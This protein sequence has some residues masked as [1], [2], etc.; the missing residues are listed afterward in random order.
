[1]KEFSYLMLDISN[2]LDEENLFNFISGLQRWAQTELRRQG[3]CELPDCDD[4]VDYK[5]GSAI[6]TMHN[7]KKDRGKKYKAKGKP[8]FTEK[9]G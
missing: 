5:M 3:V 4:W 8:S 6:N 7:S 2:M 9:V 1:M